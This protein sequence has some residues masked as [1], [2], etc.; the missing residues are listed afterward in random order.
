[1]T[2]FEGTRFGE[3]IVDGRKHGDVLVV[4]GKVAERNREKLKLLYGTSHIVGKEELEAL[5]RFNPQAVVIG[6]GQYDTLKV[7]EEVRST[8]ERQ[9]IQL[10]VEPTPKAIRTF[11]RL[12]HE[13]RRV[14]ALIH[15]TC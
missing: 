2:F 14:N 11:N 3:V 10:V 1:M 12:F 4:G 8:F 6:T 9:D 15:T 7:S 5:L 13:S